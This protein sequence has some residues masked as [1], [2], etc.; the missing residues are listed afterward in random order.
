MAEGD[1]NGSC[2]LQTYAAHCAHEHVRPNSGVL[3]WLGQLE[4]A[5]ILGRE[6]CNL[7]DNLIGSQGLL[8][9]LPLLQ[10][11]FPNLHALFLRGNYLSNQDVHVLARE[12]KK[13]PS[14]CVL[15]V[16]T[17]PI[18]HDAGRTLKRLVQSMPNLHDVRVDFTHIPPAQA[19]AIARL[20]QA[21]QE[22]ARTSTSSS[23]Q[24]SAPASS[25]PS[26]ASNTPFAALGVV[27]KVAE[28]EAAASQQDTAFQGLQVLQQIRD[29]PA[30]P[31]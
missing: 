13:L 18:T 26:S 30:E 20:C 14:L 4:G 12:L 29:V 16:G 17:N 21:N 3:H 22:G 25:T 1:A 31:L 28:C 7:N 15:D 24:P 19:Q 6:V 9:L 2:L 11:H 23:G 8:P 5:D 27:F 10:T